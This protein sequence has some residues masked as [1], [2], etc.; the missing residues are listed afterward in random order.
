MT[1]NERSKFSGWLPP[2]KEA[3]SP[4]VKKHKKSKEENT[5]IL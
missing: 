4:P 3:I 5:L 1:Q 2:P